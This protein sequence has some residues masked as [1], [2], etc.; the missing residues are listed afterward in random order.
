M[1]GLP[2]LMH[3]VSLINHGM[4]AFAAGTFPAGE[5]NSLGGSRR[6][7]LLS[8]PQDGAPAQPPPA[9]KGRVNMQRRPL[10][11]GCYTVQQDLGGR[12]SSLW[13]GSAPKGA[14]TGSTK[15]REVLIDPHHRR[16]A[17]GSDSR[18]L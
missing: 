10:T 12:E 16:G 14:L 11:G 6:E 4:K 1:D 17:G 2:C 15:N 13:W 18:M 8:D 9:L 5:Q 3:T 7:L